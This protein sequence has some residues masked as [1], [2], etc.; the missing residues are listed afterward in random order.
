MLTMGMMRI[1]VQQAPHVGIASVKSNS[2]PK[3]DRRLFA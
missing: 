3:L 2:S 1:V